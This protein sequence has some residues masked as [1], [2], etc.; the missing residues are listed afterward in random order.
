MPISLLD[1]SSPNTIVVILG[2]LVVLSIF[3]YPAVFTAPD[4][5]MGAYSSS[6]DGPSKQRRTQALMPDCFVDNRRFNV[7]GLEKYDEAHAC[8]LPRVDAVRLAHQKVRSD[9]LITE[10][11]KPTSGAR[12]P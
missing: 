1:G 8:I 6:A 10:L 7:N 3:P 12:C 9:Y 4:L 5:A 11:R 2:R